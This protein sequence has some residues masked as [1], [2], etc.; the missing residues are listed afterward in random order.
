MWWTQIRGTLAVG[1]V[2]VAIVLAWTRIENRPVDEITVATTSTT[3]TTTSTTTTLSQDDKNARICEEARVFTNLASTLDPNNDVGA[4][5]RLALDFWSDAEVMATGG[6][7]GE[8]HAVVTYYRDYLDTAAPF[9]FDTA[10]IIV[11]GGPD[12]KEKIQQLLTRPAPGLEA[13]RGLILFGCGI[14]V[15]DQPSMGAT[16]FEDLEDRLLNPPEDG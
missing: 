9:D 2:I 11:E 14:E 13:S 12:K 16:A 10:R 6:A 8:I 4:L 3:T 5:A 1:A 7:R 15:P